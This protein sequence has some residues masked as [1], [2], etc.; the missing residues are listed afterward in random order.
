MDADIRSLI[1]VDAQAVTGWVTLGT[2]AALPNWTVK[3]RDGASF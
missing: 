3:I 2:M 1:G